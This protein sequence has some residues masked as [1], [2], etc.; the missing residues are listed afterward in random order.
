MVRYWGTWV[1]QLVEHLPSAQV[2][3]PGSWD[4]VLLLPLPV[5]LPLSLCLL[6]INKLNLKKKI[7]KMVRSYLGVND[8]CLL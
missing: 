7:K 8:Q 1:A 4:Q 5:S 3:I 6:R 2:V